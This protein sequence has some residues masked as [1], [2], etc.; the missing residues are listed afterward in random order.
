MHEVEDWFWAESTS[1]LV[2]E[3]V[4]VPSISPVDNFWTVGMDGVG[5]FLFPSQGEQEASSWVDPS[6]E[7]FSLDIFTQ[8]NG[9]AN[10]SQYAERVA[11]SS[12]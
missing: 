12:C 9:E 6:P 8:F 2:A 10:N 3:L 4:G 7:S 1:D 5:T 11:S